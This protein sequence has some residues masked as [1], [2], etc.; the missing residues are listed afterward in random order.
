M[1]YILVNLG[2][3]FMFLALATKDILLLRSILILGQLSLVSFG[4]LSDNLYVSFWNV[5][6]F[7]INSFHIVRLLRERRKIEL[8]AEL[9]DLYERVFHSM[10][11]RE[12]LMFWNMGRTE[13]REGDLRSRDELFHRESRVSRCV[14]EWTS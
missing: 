14:C 3:F 2:Y 12:F 9:I 7:G 8:P 1:T 13:R 5:L 6:F 10:S 11:R 4:Y